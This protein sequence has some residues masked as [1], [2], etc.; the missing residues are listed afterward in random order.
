MTYYTPYAQG[1]SQDKRGSLYSKLL[2]LL[3]KAACHIFCL[4]SDSVFIT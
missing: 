3:W 1:H 2:F 4:I